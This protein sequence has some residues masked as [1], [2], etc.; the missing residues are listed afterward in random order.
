MLRSFLNNFQEVFTS[1]KDIHNVH[2]V[3]LLNRSKFWS[4][5]CADLINYVVDVY[6]E[7]VHEM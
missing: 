4:T 2:I 1:V 7:I 3:G 6:E 5:K